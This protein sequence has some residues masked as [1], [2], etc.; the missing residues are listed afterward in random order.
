MPAGKKAASPLGRN[1][2][3]TT[4]SL[5]LCSHLSIQERVMQEDIDGTR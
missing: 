1:H 2:D 4:N 3:I 5:H